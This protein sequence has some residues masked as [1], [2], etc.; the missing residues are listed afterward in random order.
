MKKGMPIH[1][2]AEAAEAQ[3]AAR[4]HAQIFTMSLNEL[5]F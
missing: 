3:L 2:L 5:N 1:L 4:V